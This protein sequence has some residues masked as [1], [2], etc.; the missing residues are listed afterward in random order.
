MFELATPFALIMLPLPLLIWLCLPRA[1]KTHQNPLKIPFFD[2]IVPLNAQAKPTQTSPFLWFYLI[3]GLT[4]FAAAGPR[5][6]G[7]PLPLKHEGHNMMLVL[8]ISGS[9]EIRDRIQYGRPTTRLQIVKQAAEDFVKRRGDSH[10]GLILFGSRAYLQTPLTKDHATVLMR[11]NDATVGLAGKTT[12]IGDALGLAVKHMQH[13]PTK[14]RVVIL[15][16]DGANNS[17]MMQPLKA[18]E[19]AKQSDIKVY[20]I[21]LSGHSGIPMFG[22]MPASVDDLDEQTLKTIANMTDGKYFHATDKRSLEQIYQLI[23]QLETVTHDN[24]SI[25]P[26]K[27]YYPDP[28]SIAFCCLMLLLGYI[29]FKGRRT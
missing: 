10:I 11:L 9:M 29:A 23:N 22:N 28:L 12:S 18:A 14:G 21:G 3:F 24:T 25:R 5:W 27:T 20:T 13:V 4:V 15:L 16:T 6:I 7:V 17:G 26:E 8:D 2:S 1:K 19:L